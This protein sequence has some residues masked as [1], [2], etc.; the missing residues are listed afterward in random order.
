MNRFRI[1]LIA[2][3]APILF[4]AACAAY[5]PRDPEPAGGHCAATAVLFETSANEPA[6]DARHRLVQRSVEASGGL[7]RFENSGDSVAQKSGRDELACL[8]ERECALYLVFELA[9][10]AGPVVRK[11]QILGGRC[12]LAAR[13]ALTAAVQVEKVFG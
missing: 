4:L 12:E 7:D 13:A 3:L 1:I 5:V 8:G 2:V 6:F 10:V 9:H 11:Q